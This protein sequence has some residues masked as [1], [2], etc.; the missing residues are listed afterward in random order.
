MTKRDQELFF[1]NGLGDHN[2]K[3]SSKTPRSPK[4]SFSFGKSASKDHIS[5]FLDLTNSSLVLVKHEHKR[6]LTSEELF[7]QTSLNQFRFS[8][9]V[10][11]FVSMAQPTESCEISEYIPNHIFHFEMGRENRALEFTNQ[12]HCVEKVVV[13]NK[14]ESSVVFSQNVFKCLDLEDIHE[15]HYFKIS[16]K[17]SD[18]SLV[19]LGISK[20][21]FFLFPSFHFKLFLPFFFISFFLLII[22]IKINIK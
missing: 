21:S 11:F 15:N 13:G 10:R 1:I 9:G 2:S 6:Q 17:S 5:I 14:G 22:K 20:F 19:L 16:I 18:P 8:K 7:F 12:A 3:S 4:S